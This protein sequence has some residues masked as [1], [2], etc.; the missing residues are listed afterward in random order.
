MQHAGAPQEL[1]GHFLESQLVQSLPNQGKCIL[2]L[3]GIAG[4]SGLPDIA[5]DRINRAG[6]SRLRRVSGRFDP[7]SGVP[8]RRSFT[9]LKGG[10]RGHAGCLG[11]ARCCRSACSFG[12]TRKTCSL[13]SSS[14]RW[15]TDLVGSA[16]TTLIC[17]CA[18]R[19][20]FGRDRSGRSRIGEGGGGGRGHFHAFRGLR[21]LGCWSGFG[22]N[23]SRPA[24]LGLRHSFACVDD[25][26]MGFRRR[27]LSCRAVSRPDGLCRL[28]AYGWRIT[29]RVAVCSSSPPFQ[30]TD[31]GC[32]F[33]AIY[34]H[35]HGLIWR[36][37]GMCW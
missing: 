29:G 35:G 20:A 23:G 26:R 32:C 10:L 30:R 8:L 1:A 6:G 7:Q 4:T 36:R 5:L 31:Y 14:I 18:G 33:S 21:V 3:G 19:C 22:A 2:L 37:C 24:C 28:R 27:W 13:C 9:D 34:I 11:S 25:V 16:T 15:P 12:N 17:K